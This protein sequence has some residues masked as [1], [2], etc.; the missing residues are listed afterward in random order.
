MVRRAPSSSAWCSAAGRW[1]RSWL[2]LSST[3]W[4]HWLVR[5]PRGGAGGWDGAPPAGLPEPL[6]H[7]L[8]AA[9]SET[10]HVLLA[11]ALESGALPEW[12][13]LVRGRAW[14]EEGLGLWCGPAAS[15]RG[16]C[17]WALDALGS[18]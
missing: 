15:G 11:K 10:Q 8:S 3:C 18:H 2:G 6:L 5:G 14:R 12:V 17:G 9:L 7:G 1:W 13:K 16:Q 4:E